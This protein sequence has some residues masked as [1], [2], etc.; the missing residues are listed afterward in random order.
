MKQNEIKVSIRNLVEFILRSGDID[1]RFVGSSRAL[2]RAL[3]GTKLHQKIQKAGGENYTA[4]VQLKY[5]K[6][7]DDFLLILEGRADGIISED[8]CIVIDEIKTTSI[9]LEYIDER[10]N[11]LH[12]AQAKCYAFSL[13]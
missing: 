7:F 6:E 4:E 5:I 13:C 8:S 10:F 9:P 12:W 2:E 11:Y 3:E 1:S